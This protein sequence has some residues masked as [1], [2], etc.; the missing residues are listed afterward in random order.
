[1]PQGQNNQNRKNTRCNT[2]TNSI[3]TFKMAH[4]K[5]TNFLMD[6][7]TELNLCV[8]LGS[9]WA[10]PDIP[11]SDTTGGVCVSH[12]LRLEKKPGKPCC[13]PGVL[14]SF[15]IAPLVNLSW[16]GCPFDTALSALANSTLEHSTPR[17]DPVCGVCTGQSPPFTP[18]RSSEARWSSWYLALGCRITAGP[19]TNPAGP[20]FPMMEGPPPSREDGC[21]FGEED[22]TAHVAAQSSKGLIH[23]PKMA[24]EW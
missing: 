24:Q 14:G 18:P 16:Q 2:V 1:M 22:L 19:R 9:S 4:I 11:V 10:G 8:W 12:L 7:G 23:T 13:P 21:S 20:E 3:K 5:K 15:I 6:Y 17:T